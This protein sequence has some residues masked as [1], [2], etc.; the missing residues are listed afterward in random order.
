MKRAFLLLFALVVL[1][2]ILLAEIP[3]TDQ[4]SIDGT[5]RYRSEIDGKDFNAD[6][7]MN[8][9]G[10]LRTQIGIR[11]VPNDMLFLYAKFKEA[12]SW[13]NQGVN[14]AATTNFYAEQA[15]LETNGLAGSDLHLRV[16]RYPLAFGRSRIIGS[17][18]FNVY[19]PRTYDAIGIL[20]GGEG[21]KWEFHYSKS[22][23]N[24][25]PGENGDRDLHLF[26]SRVQLMDG[27]LE[28]LFWVYYDPRVLDPGYVGGTYE[29]ADLWLTPGV[30]FN[31]KF[32]AIALKADLAGQFGTYHDRDLSGYLLAADA[33]YSI[34]H[35]I[36]PTIGVGLD[37]T[38]GTSADD[39]AEKKDHTIRIPYMSRHT[40]RGFMDFFKD[41]DEGMMSLLLHFEC[42]PM[43]K[44]R[45]N[46]DVH[47]FAYVV[48][49][50]SVKD[51]TKD[52]TQMG[53]EVDIRF[54][55]PVVDGLGIDAA[56]CIFMPSEDYKLDA[57]MAHYTYIALTAKF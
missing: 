21:L 4:V 25:D 11:I 45:M 43:A 50:T 17:A 46:V 9:F 54:R 51:A 32:G 22:S 48:E 15:Y 55:F 8:E 23:P 20:S 31:K 40:Y 36:R 5:I 29:K 14:K 52:Y 53:Q 33:F 37:Y 44:L 3:L 10:T 13:G 57:D 18:N 27:M 41:V 42:Y 1:P 26:L 34:D 35:S 16:G 6:T 7:G 2:G 12:R 30:Y 19:G 28:P 39:I 47:N 38:T 49:Q 56:H 24:T